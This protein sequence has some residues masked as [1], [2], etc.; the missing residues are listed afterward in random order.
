MNIEAANNWP[1]MVVALPKEK[2]LQNESTSPIFFHNHQRPMGMNN[3][4]EIE[5]DNF[6]AK[7]SIID[8]YI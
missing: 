2:A 6:W 8:I 1:L 5:S 7:G 4:S 3:G